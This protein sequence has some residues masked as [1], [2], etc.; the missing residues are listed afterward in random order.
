[1]HDEMR[2]C[3]MVAAA[4]LGVLAAMAGADVLRIGGGAGGGPEA[5]CDPATGAFT[6][7]AGEPARAYAYG[8]A[9]PAA[10]VVDVTDRTFGKGQCIQAPRADGGREEIL[11]FPGV[12]FI[13]FRT[14]VRN[15][16]AAPMVLDRVPTVAVTLD[17]GRP[18]DELKALG[19]GGL[20]GLASKP[21]SYMWLAVAD[22][23][24]R[25]GAVGGWLTTDRGSGVVLAGPA[26][27][28][29]DRHSGEQH[30]AE[31]VPISHAAL[32]G[33]VEYGRLRIAAGA[34]E[35]LETFALGYFDDARLGL[36]A[37]ASRASSK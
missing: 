36:E 35:T 9:Q 25:R 18:V 16:G 14:T 5:R 1:M 21:G 15:G 23:A 3:L 8:K 17:L 11:A 13:L 19:T 20:V 6:L 37:W 24:T 29:G 12:P 34:S 10:K 27:G 7:L 31:P 2:T 28:N 22:P 32:T 33:Q 4:T 26:E 30:A